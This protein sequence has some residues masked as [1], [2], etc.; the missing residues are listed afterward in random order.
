VPQL[1]Y[2]KM[3][4]GHY[5]YYSYGEQGFNWAHP[6]IAAGLFSAH[7]GWLV[8]TPIMA[9]ALAGMT[10]YRGTRNWFLTL[11]TLVPLYIYVIYSWYCYTYINGFGSRPMIN[12]YPL[13][14]IPLAA[15]F[16]VISKRSMLVKATA[17]GI[18]LLFLA[19]NVSY[20]LQEGKDMLRS[21]T[22]NGVYNMQ[23]LFKR[24]LQYNDLVTYDIAEVQPDSNTV[25]KIKTLGERHFEDPVPEHYVK[26]GQGASK[27]VYEMKD[28]EYIPDGIMVTYH[29]TDFGEA[30]YIKC[31][32]RFMY[33]LLH[34]GHVMVL[35]LKDN[36]WH[37]C[38]IENKI[39]L[40][41]G[42]CPLWA[43]NLTH[44]CMN[45]WGTVSYFVKLPANI[46]EGATINFFVWSPNKQD[47][48]IDDLLMELYE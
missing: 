39:D 13:L 21:E 16:H 2:W 45:K 7:N 25:R 19:V 41:D 6:M 4:T 29:K 26:G 32:G 43:I 42:S 20:S 47:L 12:I 5:V 8:Y 3:M 27:Y 46:K 35:D 44:F 38:T 18:V 34:G 33:P 28:D 15:F 30:R 22:S 14:A 48:F 36:K 31:S 1:L 9:G 37:G 10:L 17:T 11:W 40:L 24:Q 23:I